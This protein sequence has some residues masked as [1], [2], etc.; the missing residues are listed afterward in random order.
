MTNNEIQPPTVQ[1]DKEIEPWVK[2][3]TDELCRQGFDL[4]PVNKLLNE[5]YARDQD[6]FR[7]LHRDY[8]A[9]MLE[10]QREL[11]L[12]LRKL[13]LN[14]SVEHL[15]ISEPMQESLIQ[16][17]IKYIGELVQYTEQQLS[18]KK[19]GQRAWIKKT[20]ADLGLSLGMQI[21]DL[22]SREVL[23]Q[24]WNPES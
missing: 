6:P 3:L 9:P 17:D 12:K 1:P 14:C 13:L 24:F 21:D 15:R 7:Q 5:Y 20:L 19:I 23:D 4:W 10:L 18:R 2:E 16:A 11:N 8:V 22:P